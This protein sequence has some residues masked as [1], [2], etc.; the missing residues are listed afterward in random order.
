MK[1]AILDDE[2]HNGQLLAHLLGQFFPEITEVQQFTDSVEAVE[3]LR[4]NP[5]D[6][7]FLDIEMPQLNGF[8]VLNRLLPMRFRVIFV[9]AYDKYAVRAFRYSA[10]DYLLKPI[11][12]EEFQKAVRKALTQ[13]PM[14]DTQLDMAR[15]IQLS[16]AVPDRLAIS[17]QDGLQ[18]IDTNEIVHC[19]SESNYTKIY[20]RNNQKILVSR[21]LKDL[22][23]LLDNEQFFRLHHSH[24]VNLRSVRRYLRGEGGEVVLE[25]G[26]NVPVARSKKE[27]FLRRFARI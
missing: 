12:V 6:L 8:D 16:D 13:A 18:M 7:L 14:Q 26:A 9:T 1:A 24:L 22:E 23:E 2:P 17:S 20:L 25:N 11:D 5:P 3:A 19:E 27:E 21:T 4:T 15:T 10:L